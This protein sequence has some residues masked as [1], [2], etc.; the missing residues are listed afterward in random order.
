MSENQGN[1][2]EAKQPI[3][4]VIKKDHENIANQVPRVPPPEEDLFGVHRLN[5]KGFDKA[6][7]IQSIFKT[8]LTLLK[9]QVGDGAY[10]RHFSL[11]K[12]ELEKACFYAKKAMATQKENQ[13]V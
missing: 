12:T 2:S 6:R 3:E 10:G 1:A 5:E 8:A 9:A 11:C 7:E 13:D 4:Q